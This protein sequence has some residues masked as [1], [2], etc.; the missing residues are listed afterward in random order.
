ME[1]WHLPSVEATGKR[2]PRVLFSR[3]EARGVLI[4]LLEGD[5]LGDH[6]LYESAVLL[7][8]TGAVAVETEG[9]AIE[10][11]A[12]TLLTFGSG[13]TRSLRASKASR[14]L[15][16]LTPWPGEG[17]FHEDAEVDPGRMPAQATE[18]PLRP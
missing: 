17:H 4:D 2:D 10:C 13:E 5:E 12:G 7:V 15:L 3:S 14:I 9:Q 11:D 18:P 1:R 8:V 16:L 6:R